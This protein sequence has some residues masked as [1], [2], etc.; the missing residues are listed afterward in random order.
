MCGWQG[1]VILSAIPIGGHYGSD[2][3]AGAICWAMVQLVW[4]RIIDRP[5]A[6]LSVDETAPV[7]A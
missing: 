2:L 4:H 7:F 1:L 5:S 3:V 6:K